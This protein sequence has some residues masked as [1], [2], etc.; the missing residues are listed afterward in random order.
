M[1]WL[2]R[3]WAGENPILVPV[4]A[5][6]LSFVVVGIVLAAT[7]RNP[8]YAYYQFLVGSFGSVYNTTDTLSRMIPLAITG[9]AFV[10]GARCSIFN[11]GIEGQLLVGA[12]AAAIAGYAIKLPPVV[13]VL[14]M[15]LVG[16]LVGG[17]FSLI[18]AWLKAYRGVNEILSTIMINY[19][20]FYLVHY[21]TVKKLQAPGVVPATPFIQK[22]AELPILMTGTRLH[23]GI[24]IA[25]ALP[26]LAYFFLWRTVLGYELRA[27]GINPQAARYH[28]I[29]VER[30]M[31]LAFFIS[32]CLAGLGGAVEIAG[33]HHRFLDQFSPGYGYDAAAISMLGLAHPFGAMA[34]A[35]LFGAL[36]TGNLQMAVSSNIPRQLVSLIQG[37]VIIFLAG[38]NILRAGLRRIVPEAHEEEPSGLATRHRIRA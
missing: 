31:M 12:L 38:Q 22:T 25:V 34:G 23:A 13:H 27:V 21:L 14:F 7:G 18:P 16:T 26:F 15:L 28:G 10:I 8:F 29:P 19:P 6:V 30:R 36:K 32:G 1:R 5:V 35:L 11:L 3:L 37:I 9:V 33:I 4:V 17:L 24:L 20:A 2:R